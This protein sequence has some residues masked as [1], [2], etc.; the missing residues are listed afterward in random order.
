[1]VLEF[2]WVCYILTV[3]AI[4]LKVGGF[5]WSLHIWK[6]AGG[7]GSALILLCCAH[8]ALILMQET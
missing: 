2:F 6:D 8:L 7:S 5:E 3:E 1:L 4:A